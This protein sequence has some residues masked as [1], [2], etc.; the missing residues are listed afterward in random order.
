MS[1]RE[2]DKLFQIR[3]PSALHAQF[4]AAAKQW[5]RPMAWLARK[6]FEREIE[7]VRMNPPIKV[8]PRKKKNR[9]A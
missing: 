1:D 3:L 2:N 9:A 4:S 5:D 7:R 8:G 6:L